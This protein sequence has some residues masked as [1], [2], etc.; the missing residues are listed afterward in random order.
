MQSWW[1]QYSS[2]RC[3]I[4]VMNMLLTACGDCCPYFENTFCSDTVSEFILPSHSSYFCPMAVTLVLLC[5]DE[6]H[7][8][9]LVQYW[10]KPELVD[11]TGLDRFNFQ[12]IESIR[13]ELHY[14]MC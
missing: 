3:V 1:Q 6:E 4:C 5:F 13:Y 2:L 10:F 14:Y 12:P 7:Q 8:K 9:L 11:I